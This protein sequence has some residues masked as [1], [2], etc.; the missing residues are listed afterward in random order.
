MQSRRHLPMSAAG[1]VDIVVTDLKT[2][3]T[4]VMTAAVTYD[5]VATDALS[6]LTAP[7][8]SVS[9]GASAPL[10]LKLLDGAGQPAPNAAITLSASRAAVIFSACQLTACTLLTD[11]SGIV[12]AQVIPQSAGAVTVFARSR[13]GSTVTSTFT[14]VQ[15]AHAITVVRPMEYLAAGDGTRFRPAVAVMA[16][17]LAASGEAVIWSASSGRVALQATNTVAGAD[18]LSM[19]SAIGS[20]RD[21]EASTV[22][23]CAWTAVCATQTLIGV[24]A[25]SLRLTVVSGDDQSVTAGNALGDVVLRVVDTAGHPVAGAVVSVYQAVSGWQAPCATAGRCAIAP[26]Y[27]KGSASILSDDVGL[28]TIT[29]LQ[30]PNTAAITKVTAAIGTQGSVTLTLQKT[31]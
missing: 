9:V 3:G 5:S 16:N 10:T 1:A 31:P 21:N 11:A 8:A 29:P 28:L 15:E 22:Q 2:G 7:P 14:A 26:V 20:L 12:T 27:G 4:T 23:A 17:G 24:P 30:Y 18:G 25:A 13:S 19:V 6:L